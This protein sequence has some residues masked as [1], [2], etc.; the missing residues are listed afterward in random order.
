MSLK[1]GQSKVRELTSIAGEYLNGS[2]QK[3]KKV[4]IIITLILTVTTT[5]MPMA[6]R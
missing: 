1:V 3:V 4:T 5:I 6:L 2:C